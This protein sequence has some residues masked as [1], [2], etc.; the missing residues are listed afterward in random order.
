LVKK[1]RRV[2]RSRKDFGRICMPVKSR[3]VARPGLHIGRAK[4]KVSLSFAGA[5]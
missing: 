1:W 5:I 2:K 3:T 4:D